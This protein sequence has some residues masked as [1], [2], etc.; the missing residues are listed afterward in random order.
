MENLNKQRDQWCKMC[1][2]SMKRRHNII[3]SF[4]CY[5]TNFKFYY[6][7]LNHVTETRVFKNLSLRKKDDCNLRGNSVRNHLRNL[8]L[9][10]NPPRWLAK[11][12]H[13]GTFRKTEGWSSHFWESQL[14]RFCYVE[15][16][17]QRRL[18]S[19]NTDIST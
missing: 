9:Y 10:S 6:S 3:I 1:E 12:R 7:H 4:L 11:R 14:F 5:K 13:M 18:K 16:H 2:Q 8:K 19:T 17:H 15:I